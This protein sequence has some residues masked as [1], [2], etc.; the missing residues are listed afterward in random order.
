M[1][2]LRVEKPREMNVDTAS[3]IVEKAANELVADI[4]RLNRQ[5]V[6]GHGRIAGFRPNYKKLHQKLSE[7]FMSLLADRFVIVPPKRAKVLR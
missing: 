4:K 3:K 2:N 7:D 6:R 5:Y 1:T